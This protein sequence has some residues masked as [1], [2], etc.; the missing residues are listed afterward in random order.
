LMT[1]A[2]AMSSLVVGSCAGAQSSS[3]PT[4]PAAGSPAAQASPAPADR[5][6]AEAPAADGDQVELPLWCEDPSFQSGDLVLGGERVRILSTCPPP[7]ERQRAEAEVP[8]RS[9]V[10]PAVTF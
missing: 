7:T 1:T 8:E 10:G 6:V 5:L 4:A 2:L 9:A 3:A